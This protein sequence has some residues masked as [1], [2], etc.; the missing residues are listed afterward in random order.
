MAAELS[1]RTL[2]TAVYGDPVEHS[3]SPAMHNAAYSAL[4]MERAYGAFRVAPERLREA[5][6]AVVA[7]GLLGVNLTVPHKERGARIIPKLSDEARLLRSV[8][9]VVNREG[10]LHADNTDARGLEADLREK[11]VEV[12]DKTI[13]IAGAG[14]AAASAVLACIRTG[15]RRI[16]VANRTLPRAVALVRRF[17][18]V[19]AASAI[20]AKPIAALNDSTLL[21]QAALVI[22]ATS[23]GLRGEEFALDYA[24]TPVDCVFYDLSYAPQATPFLRPAL[25]LERRVYDGAGMLVGQGELAFELFN[26]IRPRSG[27]MHAV[28]MRHLGRTQ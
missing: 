15:A 14:G 9:C 1:G 4:G 2:F 19:R 26:G 5:L 25:A 7:L 23:A 17:T 16:V 18:R 11:R 8:N 20:E 10:V 28:L 12:I 27:I 6:R 24:E 13:V 22:N 3:L 21:R